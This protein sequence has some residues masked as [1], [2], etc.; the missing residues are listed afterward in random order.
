M[1]NRAVVV[2][3]IVNTGK[4]TSGL[5]KASSSMLA[6]TKQNEQAVS[7]LS[8]QIGLLGVGLTGFAALAVKKFAD[9]DAAMSTVSSATNATAGDLES[10]RTAALDAGTSTVYSATEAANA[11]TELGKAGLSTADITGGALAG[12]LDLAASENM[13]V[14][15]AAELTATALGQ[16]NL[17]GNEASHVADLLAA[18]AGKAQGSAADL[19]QALNQAGGIANSFGISI[20]DTSAALALFAS[21]GL[22]GSDA[23]TSL[24]TMLIAL[25]N[26]AG[27]TAAE[28]ERL[29]INAYDASGNFIGLEALAGQLQ[30]QL[31]G[32]DQATRNA[33]LAQIFGNDAYRA[34]N[35]LMEA[36][37]SGFDTWTQK[38]NDQGYAAEAAAKR[39]DNLKGDLEALSGAFETALIGMGEGGDGALRG[40]VQSVTDVVNAF[41]GLPDGVQQAS[42]AIIGGGGLVALGVAGLMKLVTGINETKT[43]MQALN[44]SAKTAGIAVGGVGAALAV[45]A[46]G[47]TVWAQ[48]AAEAQARTDGYIATLDEL[49][50][51]TD[52]T[53]STIAAALAESDVKTWFG[54]DPQSL[55]QIGEQLGLTVQDLTG[56]IL[57]VDEAVTKVNATYQDNI[58]GTAGMAAEAEMLKSRLDEESGSLSEAE[59]EAARKTEANEA[60]GVSEGNAASAMGEVIDAAQEQADALDEAWESAQR[61]T[62]EALDV[63]S[64][65]RDLQSAIDDASKSVK[66]NGTTLDISTE[67]G[68]AN[69]A[70]LDDI[71]R[72]GLNLV[73]AQ[74]EQGASEKT[75]QKTMAT[76]RDKFI[77]AAEAMGV[78]SAKAEALADDLGLIPTEVTPKVAV[79]DAATT[80]INNIRANLRGLDGDSATTYINTVRT[81]SIIRRS[82]K[83]DTNGPASG[84]GGMGTFAV[85]GFTGFGGTYE[86]AGLVHRG[87]WVINQQS[88]KEID[89]AAPGFLDMLNQKGAQALAFGGFAKGGRVDYT[90]MGHSLEYWQ[91]AYRDRLEKTQLQI[92]ARDIKRDLGAKVKEGK[93]KGQYELRGLDRTEAAL[94][95]REVQREL[96]AARQADRARSMVGGNLAAAIRK[97]DAE[98]ERAAAAKEKA[99][100]Q[101]ASDKEK[102]QEKRDN[103]LGQANSILSEL[104]GIKSSVVNTISSGFALANVEGTLNQWTGER[105][106]ATGKQ[107]LQAAQAYAAKAKAFAGKLSAL[108][109]KGFSGV[110]LQEVAG[111]GIEAGTAAADALLSL[112]A[113]DTKAF[114][115]AYAEID[116]WANYAGDAVTKGFFKGGEQAAAGIVAG[117]ESGKTSVEKAVAAMANGMTDAFTKALGIKSPSRV[118]RALMTFVGEGA[119]LGLHDQ[120]SPVKEAAADLLSVAG[121][122]Y[123]A[124]NAPGY[125]SVPGSAYASPS[126]SLGDVTASMTDDQ[127]R[128]L[129]GYMAEATMAATDVQTMRHLKTYASVQNA[130]RVRQQGTRR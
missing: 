86:P 83:P 114:N 48:N 68:R 72:S 80:V 17:E 92:R 96:A 14:A 112:N 4:W 37:A 52:A 124:A 106:P 2:D 73:D 107:F 7:H 130:H 61:F 20:E 23:G 75:L 71:A 94:Q 39:L 38:V 47:L 95:L 125:A 15:D 28:M 74:R 57:G 76:T 65:Q 88:S 123:T 129:A 1:S 77:A 40:L 42:L 29:G 36:G 32:L 122:K 22:I 55:I 84:N 102:A 59:K 81:E 19:G 46:I 6:A 108:Q 26:P 120:Q 78:G 25:A 64:A 93:R 8:T 34:A 85:G 5:Q 10:L 89:A 79:E 97:R 104:T 18:G 82:L 91:N 54:D 110:I 126:V 9:F 53:R 41:N 128:T 33:A 11:I 105:A 115:T 103:A 111:M 69:Q 119:V 67:K 49:G 35:Y 113:T 12:A 62:D 13:A 66:E 16:F 31:G 21:N 30:T 127:M 116:R 101:K 121:G 100:Q 51:V 60:L 109:S 70:A 58:Q 43:A 24:K 27:K 3:L 50:R 45:A 117:L 63:R 87:E 44:V 99:K 56:Y 98:R 118:F 90:P